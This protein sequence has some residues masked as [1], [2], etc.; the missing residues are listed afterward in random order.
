MSGMSCPPNL[1]MCHLSSPFSV[2][3]LRS[4]VLCTSTYMILM[5]SIQLESPNLLIND[6]DFVTTPLLSGLRHRH[7][8]KG[9]ASH[10]EAASRR[11]GTHDMGS[12]HQ[13]WGG[14]HRR[15]MSTLERLGV[16]ALGC[17]S[18][19]LCGN[20]KLAKVQEILC[21]GGETSGS[22]RNLSRRDTWYSMWL[23]VLHLATPI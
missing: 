3:P 6:S 21:L 11:S 17:V 19:F 23:S 2:F 16:A 1:P 8:R 4:Y 13:P 10:G 12:Q 20:G 9:A 14:E 18:P 15:C 22:S 5:M 7:R